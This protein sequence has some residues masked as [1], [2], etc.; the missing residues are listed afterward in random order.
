MQNLQKLYG[1]DIIYD[2]SKTVR[3]KPA[4]MNIFASITYELGTLKH[5]PYVKR[6]FDEKPETKPIKT[7]SSTPIHS[8]HLFLEEDEIRGEQQKQVTHIDTS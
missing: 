3:Q 8:N 7:R 5:E 4:G 6:M 1:K 2:E